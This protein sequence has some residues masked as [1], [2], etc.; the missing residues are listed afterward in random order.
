M[1]VGRCV[2]RSRVDAISNVAIMAFLLSAC[3]VVFLCL[4]ATPSI[5]AIIQY[6]DG[7]WEYQNPV[8]G[9]QA[10][11]FT[12]PDEYGP[13]W[14]LQT[15]SIYTA[16]NSI[17]PPPDNAITVKIWQDDGGS[18]GSVLFQLDS[19]LGFDFA[20]YDFDVSSANLTFSPGQ[21]FFGGFDNGFGHPFATEQV[22]GAWDSTDPDHGG[23]YFYSWHS[24]WSANPD[25]PLIRASGSIVP[26]P[27]TLAIFA[28]F[29]G[30]GFLTSVWRR[31]KRN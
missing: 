31:R 3:S 29:G 10:T 7:N 27:S 4:G 11:L 17:S 15:L 9:G 21:S 8:L 12:V 28:A 23:Y 24:T 25:D 14:R 5:A 13:S 22:H 26:E 30:I 2:N 18:M 6:D 20:W 1:R 19:T 16:A